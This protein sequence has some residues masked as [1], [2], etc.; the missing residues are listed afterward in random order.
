MNKHLSNSNFTIIIFLISIIYAFIVKNGYIGFGIDYY[1]AYHKK[2]FNPFGITDS[3]G[4]RLSTLYVYG[5]HLGTLLTPLIIA[6]TSGLLLKHFFNI[7]SLNSR[8]IFILIFLLILFSWPVVI[9]TNNAM[10]QGLLMSFLIV[11][12]VSIS[13]KNYFLAFLFMSISIFT[14]KSGI[15]FISIILF[16]LFFIKF[17]KKT[18]LNSR[19]TILIFGLL[20]FFI[21]YVIFTNIDKTIRF[22]ENKAIGIDFRP[23]FII[24]DLIF[25]VYF[26][27]RYSGRDNFICLY[28][29]FFSFSTLALVAS[30]LNW[31]FERYNMVLIPTY[32]I[33]S[34]L[35]F[36]R[37][38]KYI[39]LFLTYAVLFF[40]TIIT[41]MYEM[42]VGV[43][44]YEIIQN[45][46]N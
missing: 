11:C 45:L 40:L 5:Y 9:S 36:S 20:N 7:Q 16:L 41:G 23:L 14:H 37:N 39:Y 10:R 44:S 8:L 33:A 2:N 25:I 24:L 28:L 35:F 13:N 34:S 1:A 19:W 3:I 15:A 17:M 43:F 29:Y 31:E 27:L 38:S 21:Y 12:L 42:G 18:S 30:G 26:T 22:D 32:I 6:L 4:W 46:T